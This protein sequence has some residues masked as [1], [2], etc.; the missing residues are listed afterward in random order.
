MF[1]LSMAKAIFERPILYS[2]TFL[3][4]GTLPVATTEGFKRE[5]YALT[6]G[7]GVFLT[8]PSGFRKMEDEFPTRKRADRN[9]LN[10]KEYMLHVLHT[11]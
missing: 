5:L 7:E 10:R 9:P 2:D 6:G 1:K 8:E 4:R 11:Y 3:L